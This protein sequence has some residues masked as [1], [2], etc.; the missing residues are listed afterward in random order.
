MGSPLGLPMASFQL[1]S[2]YLDEVDRP[3]PKAV[4]KA[5]VKKSNLPSLLHPESYPLFLSLL[6]HFIFHVNFINSKVPLIFR[7]NRC[8]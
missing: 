6:T 7:E 2:G 5:E 8:P 1:F 4:K 3:D